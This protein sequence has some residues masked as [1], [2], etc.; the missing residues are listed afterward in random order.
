MSLMTDFSQRSLIL[1]LTLLPKNW[2]SRAAGW[3]ASIPW[4]GPLMRLHIRIFG[5]IFGVNMS[6][7]KAPLSSFRTLNKFFARELKDGARPIDS[8]PDAL[9]SPCDG[10]WGACGVVE[11][12]Q[13]L[14]VKGRPYTVAELLD[15]EDDAKRFE[16]GTF[17]TLYLSPKDYHRYHAPLA[18]D[19]AKA[20]YLPGDLWP[21]N[22]AGVY[23]VDRLFARNERS[24]LFFDVKDDEGNLQ[25]QM[26]IVPVG[27]TMVGKIRIHMDADLTSNEIGRKRV[28]KNYDPPR[29]IARGEDFGQFE[30]GSTLVCVATKGLC[31]W[32]VQ[33]A[34]TPV[35]LG[36]RIGTVGVQ[37]VDSGAA[38]RESVEA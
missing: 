21:V 29:P 33:P 26:A 31:T 32:D 35:V 14:Q 38:E 5:A 25:G 22:N 37:R 36:T 10:A 15:D 11:D 16:G 27:A 17:A 1:L 23:K 8:A 6:E 3:F 30:F 19:V 34:G 20:R 28:E 13:I 7:V 9:V 12:G 18:G 4:P 2:M 24:I